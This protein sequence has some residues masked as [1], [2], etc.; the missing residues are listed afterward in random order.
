MNAL[1]CHNFDQKK[2]DVEIRMG[3][4]ADATERLDDHIEKAFD[5]HHFQLDFQDIEMVFE[6]HLMNL[7]TVA[8]WIALSQHVSLNVLFCC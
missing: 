1:G 4:H 6:V 5:A 2:R 3:S 7:M 8:Y